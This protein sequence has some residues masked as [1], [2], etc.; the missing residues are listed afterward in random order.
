MCKS[1]NEIFNEAE[2]LFAVRKGKNVSSNCGQVLL[3]FCNYFGLIHDMFPTR[4]R[5]KST[6]CI[7][8][9]FMTF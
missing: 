2:L 6:P 4:N 1:I 8:L 3:N 7:F 9:L 5:L